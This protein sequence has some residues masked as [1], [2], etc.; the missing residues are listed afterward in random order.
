[1]AGEISSEGPRVS[2]KEDNNWISLQNFNNV[3]EN[4]QI[5]AHLILLA[6][7]LPLAVGSALPPPPPPPP[8]L[9]VGAD[10]DCAASADREPASPFAVE[11]DE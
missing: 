6:F 7:L 10:D 5:I 3:I 1:M 9:L 8:S 4:I 11:A 2:G